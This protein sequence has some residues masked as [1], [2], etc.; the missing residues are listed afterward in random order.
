MHD[1]CIFSFFSQQFI[2][3]QGRV[4]FGAEFF[5]FFF[6]ILQFKKHNLSAYQ[7]HNY[8]RRSRTYV[9][10][11]KMANISPFRCPKILFDPFRW[12]KNPFLSLVGPQEI[13]HSSTDRRSFLLSVSSRLTSGENLNFG[14]FTFTSLFGTARLPTEFRIRMKFIH[15][16]C[17][18]TGC[19][20]V[21]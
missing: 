13:Q 14:P 7:Y 1:T 9:F 21:L 6:L 2:T 5:F 8:I 16:V 12:L 20:H 17:I 3:V 19:E 10:W 11:L 18:R 15:R 4:L